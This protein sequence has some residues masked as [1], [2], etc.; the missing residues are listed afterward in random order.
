[1]QIKKSVFVSSLLACSLVFG[2]VGVV[3]ST[4]VEKISA[5]LNH[6]IKFLLNGKSWTPTDVNGNE[7]SALVYKGSTYVPL[8][9]VSNA[10]GANV[11]YDPNT[12]VITI[13]GSDSGVPYLDN[14]SGGSTGGSTSGNTSGGS[15]TS[16]SGSTTTTATS[17]K[18]VMIYPN[19]F[20]AKKIAESD[21]RQEAVKLIKIYGES[22]ASKNTSKFDAY[23]KEKAAA[24][25]KYNIVMGH[26]YAIESYAELIEDTIE[27]N[28][29]KTITAYA[30]TMKS[31]TAADLE[32]SDA[33][34]GEYSASISF[35]F[36]P[37]DWDAFSSV[38]IY[39]KFSVQDDGKYVLDYI[40]LS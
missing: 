28:D 13:D 11:D 20:D 15:S 38:Y 19:N 24:K 32:L 6:S 40:Y 34:K 29:A 4:G 25:T 37:E 17:S 23:I 36:Y 35:S 30:N 33:Y 21:L 5:S 26:D 31:V 39:F 14:S 3:A 2:S 9:A 7:L 18:G 22:L 16:N 8:R 1:M 12:L 10:L 27:A